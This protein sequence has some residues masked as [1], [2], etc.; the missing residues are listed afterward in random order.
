VNAPE[1]DLARFLHESGLARAGEPGTWMPLSGGV[2]S[3]IWRVETSAGSFC[4]KRARARLQVA[5]QWEAPIDRNAYEWAYM[6][7]AAAI[8]PGSVPQPIA[9]DARR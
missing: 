1:P 4:V 9:H 2:S 5:A 8:V 7:I 3:D 6:Q